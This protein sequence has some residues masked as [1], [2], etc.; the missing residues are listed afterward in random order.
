[1]G[2]GLRKGVKLGKRAFSQKDIM[3]LG[4]VAKCY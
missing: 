2:Q 4:D 3:Y 1:M